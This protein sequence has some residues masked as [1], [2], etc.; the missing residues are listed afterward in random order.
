MTPYWLEGGTETCSGCTHLYVY[1][2]EY[3]CV[4]CD[5]GICCHC[6]RFDVTTRDVLCAECQAE[7][8]ADD[9]SN[10]AVDVGSGEDPRAA[11]DPE[12]DG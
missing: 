12:A 9:D 10:S 7:A 5:R 6:V 11:A 2:M 8:E 4:A 3:R 1:Q